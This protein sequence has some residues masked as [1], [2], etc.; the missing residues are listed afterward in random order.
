MC[1]LILFITESNIANYEDDTT[2][3]EWEANLIETR[4]NTETEYLKVFELFQNNYLKASSTKSRVM[5]TT[6]NIV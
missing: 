2:L 5:L 1:D 3:Y 6:D 4:T